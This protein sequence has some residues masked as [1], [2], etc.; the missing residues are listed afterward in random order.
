MSFARKIKRQIKR[1]EQ[2]RD[3]CPKC[4]SKLYDKSGYGKV[5]AECGWWK[6]KGG[7]D[8]A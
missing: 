4:H 3:T 5:C 8:N 6:R 1:K 2:G 7:A